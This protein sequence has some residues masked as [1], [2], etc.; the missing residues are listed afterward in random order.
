[1]NNVVVMETTLEK[2]E[3]NGFG[4]TSSDFFTV[5]EVAL[6]GGK[7]LD[8]VGAC[9]CTPSELFLE[10]K[11]DGTAI[12]VNATGTSTVSIDAADIAYIN[13]I[14]EGDQVKAGER[15]PGGSE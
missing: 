7:E 10:G 13:T 14:K 3:Y 2:E 8:S 11:S 15:T 12:T 4:L 6:A 1:M 5:T 9:E